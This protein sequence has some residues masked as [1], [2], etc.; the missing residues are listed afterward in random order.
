MALTAPQLLSLRL[1]LREPKSMETILQS[2]LARL[3]A[4]EEAALI[5]LLTAFDADKNNVTIIETAGVKIDPQEKVRL[6]RA[7]IAN[8][9]GWDMASD[10]SVIV[11]RGYIGQFSRLSS[12]QNIDPEW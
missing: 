10:N 12:A 9:L 7:D 1:A 11:G 3:N 5:V 6:I 2:A 8:T 4:D